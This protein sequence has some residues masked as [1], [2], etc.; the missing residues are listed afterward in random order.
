MAASM[1]SVPS[2]FVA[3]VSLLLLL[4]TSSL[5]WVVPH[6][7]IRQ[8]HASRLF[9]S[10]R[11]GTLSNF[12]PR[13]EWLAMSKEERHKIFALRRLASTQSPATVSPTTVAP[14]TQSPTTTSPD[15]EIFK[16][17]V[18]FFNKDK[19]F[20]FITYD[21]YVED[22]F[23]HE[24]GFQAKSMGVGKPVEFQIEVRDGKP[25]AARVTSRPGDQPL[26][27]SKKSPAKPKAVRVKGPGGEPLKIST[28]SP[29]T[30]SPTTVA[31]STQSS[32]TSSLD[33][34]IFTTVSLD[35]GI[36]KGSVKWFD[37]V[38]GFGFITRHDDGEDIFVHQSS[39]LAQG[40]RAVENGEEVEFQVEVTAG[41]S[42]AVHVTSPGGEPLKRG[43][44]YSKKIVD[45]AAILI[46]SHYAV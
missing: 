19:G 36:F 21:D 24:S 14:S 46:Q 6:H 32:T 12:T 17:S 39:I 27:I 18:K 38:K 4:V 23:V 29:A 10:D 35:P 33:R 40:F 2:H 9:M 8:Q 34:G 43:F 22:I 26:K 28:K 5:A 25:R 16:G 37:K 30:V 31:P 11:G 20:G 44:A 42:K 7:Q 15:S 45:L 41:K 3:S 13:D 1:L